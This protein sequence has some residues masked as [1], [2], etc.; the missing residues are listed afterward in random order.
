M[1]DAKFLFLDNQTCMVCTTCDK[2][3]KEGKNFTEKDILAYR[4]KNYIPSQYCSDE[5][6]IK[7]IFNVHVNEIRND[8]LDINYILMHITQEQIENFVEQELIIA[9][10]INFHIGRPFYKLNLNINE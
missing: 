8:Y 7:D 3:L 2:V 9:D 4:G 10:I 1:A 5:C 6:T